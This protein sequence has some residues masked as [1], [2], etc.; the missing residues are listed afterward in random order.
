AN[1]SH[2]LRTPL[3]SLL[4]LS[5]IL[6][7][8]S[9]GNLSEAQVEYAQTI[10]QSGNDLL[11]LI[12][13]ILDLA[14][15]ESGT[16]PVEVS[17]VELRSLQEYVERSFREVADHKGLS[18]QVVLQ[19]PL[20]SAI[21]TDELRLR[22]VM[23]N[24]ISNAIKFTEEGGVQVEVQALMERFPDLEGVLHQPA[25]A[26]RV[27]D[28]G[29]GIPKDKQSVIFEAF[30]QAD[31]GTSRTYGGTGLGLSISREIAW[32]LGGKIH[33]ASA[34][35]QGSCFSLILPCDYA[36]RDY[37][38]TSDA[39][40]S[41]PFAKTELDVEGPTAPMGIVALSPTS[42][43]SGAQQGEAEKRTVLIVDDD[44]RNI[45]ALRVL[46]VEQDYAVLCAETGEMALAQLEANPSVALVFMDIMMPQMDGFETTRL[47]RGR[48]QWANLPVI[49]LTA[50]AMPGDRERCLEAGASDYV[51][52]PVDL[53]EVTRC[54]E[55]WVPRTPSA[56]GP[57]A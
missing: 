51:T 50:Q 26:F 55:R 14:K 57:H 1:M 12:N 43:E 19:Q 23:R 47:I 8:N 22:Q 41:F 42:V 56:Q 30:R 37:S 54:L 6:A 34:P 24:L 20:P 21:L 27:K 7:K 35:G 29:I 9:H 28:T 33:V 11:E 10:N 36:P 53:E 45:N 16:M 46:L 52:K 3:N 5:Q 40:R 13:E 18:F 25:L 44:P 39:S 32:L 2:E 17:H 31:G 48:K 4:I 15:I 49:A 38:D